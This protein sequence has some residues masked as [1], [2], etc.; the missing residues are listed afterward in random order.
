MAW[1][2]PTIDDF[3]AALS[4]TEARAYGKS[5]DFS[6]D[7]IGTKLKNT[8]AAVRGY[9]RSG[10]KCRMPN[11]ERLLP[12]FLISPAMSYMVFEL[13]TRYGRTV[14]ASREKTYDHARE[15]FDKIAQ[16]SIV[17]EDYGET[18]EEVDVASSL[19]KPSV[20]RKRRL[21]GRNQEGG[22]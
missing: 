8:V 17:P 13:L 14:N 16:G 19:P 2:E 4:E 21:L 6:D 15:L 11:D 3:K 5:D 10:R 20:I 1:R 7:V 18:P 9:I 22:I 12:E